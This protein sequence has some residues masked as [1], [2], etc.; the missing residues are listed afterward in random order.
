[1]I[2]RQLLPMISEKMF[3]RKAIVLLGARQTGKS[4]LVRK[5]VEE[6]PQKSLWLNA[7]NEPIRQSLELQNV[8]LLRSPVGNA[9]VVVI[10]E[11]QRVR[12]I[13]ITAKIIIDE[14]P[15]KQLI[16]IGSSALELANEIN[17][18]LTG[19]KWQYSLFP[20]CWQELCGFFDPA[21]AL[22]QL[23]QRLVYGMYPDVVMNAGEETDRLSDLAESY[24]YKD[25]L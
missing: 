16:L 4:T 23:P 5:I 19:R 7:D 17:E 9:S 15:D 14:M 12:N 8:A 13:G 1:M 2:Y 10:D 22:M 11:A 18:P 3:Q 6:I 25:I 21:T 20:I 24:L